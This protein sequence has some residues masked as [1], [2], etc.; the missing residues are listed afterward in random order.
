MRIKGYVGKL[1]QPRKLRG[2][3]RDPA[4]PVRRAI[5]PLHDGR[6][7]RTGAAELVDRKTE[8]SSRPTTRLFGDARRSRSRQAAA[9]PL[10]AIRCAS[11][12]AADGHPRRAFGSAVD[13]DGRGDEARGARISQSSKSKAKATHRDWK[14]RSSPTSRPSASAAIARARSARRIDSKV[15]SRMSARRYTAPVLCRA[16]KEKPRRRPPGFLTLASDQSD[17]GQK[18]RCTRRMPDHTSVVRLCEPRRIEP[19]LRRPRC[20]PANAV[21]SLVYI[22]SRP[23]SRFVT[24]FQIVREPACQALKSVQPAP[25]PRGS[26]DAS[27]DGRAVGFVAG[28]KN[29][30]SRTAASWSSNAGSQ[31]ARSKPSAV[32]VTAS[33]RW[34]YA[35]S[36]QPSA[37][38]PS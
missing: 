17:Q 6:L 38:P 13:R 30:R 28:C 14:A 10:G 3:R 1:P 35:S 15:P 5:H 7:A 27:V 18:L 34:K 32:R 25:K 4:P 23:I 21:S 31:P 8:S 20:H 26:A 9:R 19:R 11:G 29:P 22:T 33:W 16:D 12:R 36:A 2:R 24:G 37:M